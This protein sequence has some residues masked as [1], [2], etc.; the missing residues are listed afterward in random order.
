MQL[1]L[2]RRVAATAWLRPS[3]RSVASGSRLRLLLL[4]GGGR[5]FCPGASWESVQVTPPFSAC[6]RARSTR[7]HQWW[8]RR[9]SLQRS[10]PSGRS[11]V[12]AGAARGKSWSVG[13]S[14]S[15]RLVWPRPSWEDCCSW[16]RRED[17]LESDK[18]PRAWPPPSSRSQWS[19][20]LPGDPAARRRPERSPREAKTLP[21]ETQV[22][23][24]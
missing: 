23:R 24:R 3:H 13:L 19:P 4:W 2:T 10:C 15:C 16:S 8:Q 17:E 9:S 1:S 5:P 11:S 14:S 6:D 20:F 12:G 21:S 22:R 7:G 18:R